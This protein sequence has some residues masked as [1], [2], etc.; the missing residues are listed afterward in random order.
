MIM[1]SMH[2]TRSTFR[3][4]LRRYGRWLA[5]SLFIVVVA[6]AAYR[7]T[8]VPTV[9]APVVRDTHTAPLDPALQSVFDYLRA[10]SGDQPRPTPVAPRDPATQSALDYIRA[11]ERADRP[12][13][14]ATPWDQATQ[15]VRDY[16]QAH[17]R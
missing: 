15:A 7:A 14:A 16:L 10:H 2:Q 13:R 11:H 8:A 6:L 12:Q 3:R 17:S 1:H 4:A 5:I 9:A